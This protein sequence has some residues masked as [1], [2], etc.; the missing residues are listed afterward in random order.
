[1]V[2]LR[3]KPNLERSRWFVILWTIASARLKLLNRRSPMSRQWSQSNLMHTSTRKNKLSN[4]EGRIKFNCY[5]DGFWC[6]LKQTEEERRQTTK[7]L[8]PSFKVKREVLEITRSDPSA[9]V[10][11]KSK[12]SFSLI[13]SIWN[14]LR[15]LLPRLRSRGHRIQIQKI[16][17][18]RRIC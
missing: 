13:A 17:C 7:H 18:E 10:V 15:E 5:F 12:E 14:S 8:V 11:E 3:G 16:H 4:L 1:M 6:N 2:A 9:I